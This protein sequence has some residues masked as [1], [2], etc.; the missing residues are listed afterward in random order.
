MYYIVNNKDDGF[1]EVKLPNRK[2]TNKLKKIREKITHK[3]V[4][5]YELIDE[6][7]TTETA[8]TE[9]NFK[10]QISDNFMSDRSG[11]LML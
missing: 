5:F 2:L 6:N 3:K 7:I 10:P 11:V 9:E 4:K 1:K 8:K